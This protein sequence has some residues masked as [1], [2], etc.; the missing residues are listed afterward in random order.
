MPSWLQSFAQHN[1]VSVLADSLRGLF[2]VN[3][4]LTTGDT[5]WALIQS[6]AWIVGILLVF[7]PL[8]VIRYRNTMAR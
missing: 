6:A 1:P 5:R 3:P 8:S 4:A 2:H 7:I